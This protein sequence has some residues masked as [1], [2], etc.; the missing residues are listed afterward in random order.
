MD[1]PLPTRDLIQRYLFNELIS[2]N[3][4]I[5]RYQGL[6]LHGIDLG[7]TVEPITVTHRGGLQ[8][9][10]LVRDGATSYLCGHDLGF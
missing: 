8:M 6:G 9:G 10:Y 3:S 4:H 1:T 2:K 5:L 7:D